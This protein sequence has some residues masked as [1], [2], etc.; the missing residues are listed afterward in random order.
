MSKGQ[1]TRE[2]IIEK[3]ASIFNKNGFAGASLSE[4]MNATGLKKGGIYNHFKNKDEIMFEAFDYAIKKFNRQIY[5]AY[6]DKETALQKLYAIIEYYKTY[7]LNPVIEGGCPIIN[8]AIDSD[9]THPALKER[10]KDVLNKWIEN[11]EY[12]IKKGQS[13]GEFKEEVDSY[14]SAV[15]IVTNMQGGVLIARSF[16]KNSYMEIIVDQLYKYVNDNLKI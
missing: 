16:E 14:K 8:T 10:V 1:S 12:I 11:L 7:P 5:Q 6:K 4:L 13:L 2:I 3:A 15:L 9:N